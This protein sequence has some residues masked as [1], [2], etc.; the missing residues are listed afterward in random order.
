MLTVKTTND[1]RY[2]DEI[3]TLYV[4]TFT[5]G[6]SK[7]YV[8]LELLSDYM[9]TILDQGYAVI[10]LSDEQIVGALL[11]LPLKFD[12]DLPDSIS[13]QYDVENCIYIAELMVDEKHRGKGIG[14]KLMI[15]FQKEMNRDKFHD[16]FI[17]VWD[18]NALAL[19]LYQKMGFVPVA[20][21][22]QNKIMPDGLTTF[23]M[24]K[25]YLHKKSR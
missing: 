24:N 3:I 16:I 11:C 20:E 6:D 23:V 25:I 19:S 17:R 9:R 13:S 18:Q 14:K 10:A 12:K 7:Q 8:D 1:F 5:V 2:L 15:D 22:T 4:K 21:I